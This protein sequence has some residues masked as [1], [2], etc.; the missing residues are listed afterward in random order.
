MNAMKPA[1][2]NAVESA[3]V[4]AAAGLVFLWLVIQQANAIDTDVAMVTLYSI[5]LGISVLAHIGF[6]MQAVRR[7]GRPLRGWALALVL[8]P[9][10]T[11]IVL[12]GLFYGIKPVASESR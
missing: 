1:V 5:S 7:D 8:L 10:I 2:K 4:A 12:L 6:M 11:S 9:F 3:L